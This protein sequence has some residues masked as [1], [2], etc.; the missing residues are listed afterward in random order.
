[1]VSDIVYQQQLIGKLH[2][3]KYVRVVYPLL[4]IFIFQLFVVLGACFIAYLSMHRKLLAQEVAEKTREFRESEGRFHDL[5][6][7]LPEMVLETDI[8]GK[9]IY[10]NEMAIRQ[11]GLLDPVRADSR[12][13][14]LVHCTREELEKNNFLDWVRDGRFESL[15]YSARGADGSL[16]PVLIRGALI[17]AETGVVGARFIIIDIT[18]HSAMEEQLRRDQKMKSIGMMAGGVAHDLNNILSGVVN[19]PELILM[20]LPEDSKVR[21]YVESMKES[22]LRAAEVV[23]DLL[24]VARGVAATKTI[25]DLNELI[26]EYL[27][28]PEFLRLKSLY[29]ELTCTTD[30]SPTVCNISC[31]L[32]HVR[33][34]LMN[35]ITNAAEAMEGKGEITVSTCSMNV[36]ALSVPDDSIGEGTYALVTVRDRGRG[37][38][39]K[40]INHIF[41]PFYTKKKMGRSGTGLGLA[42]V[43]NTMQDHGG[44]AT[45][46]SSRK[47]TSFTLYFPC[48][49]S[50]ITQVSK[51]APEKIYTGNG[52]SILVVDDEPQQQDIARQLLGSMGYQVE[53]VASGEEAIQYLDKKPADLLVLDM[54]L[55]PGLNGR[56]TYEEILRIRPGQK[57]VIVSGYSESDDVKTTLQLGAGRLINKPYTREQISR[58]VHSELNS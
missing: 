44:T 9:I 10:A 28:S 40:D 16:F 46:T 52:E 29:P 5:V 3:V 42:V 48:V 12:M 4:N 31:S 22:G 53:T 13:Y 26:E 18:E 30:L 43:W 15:E 23:A 14:E 33:K 19:Y 57:A 24:T 45:V 35:L 11:F 36:D 54:I 7:L 17:H 49:L 37:I 50:D 39:K 41:E 38:S 32:I 27:Q 34:C 55:G 56:E 1:M 6:N 25:A 58:A 8:E 47:G 51:R 2:G 21:N 20:N